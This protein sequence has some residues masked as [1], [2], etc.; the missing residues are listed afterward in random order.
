MDTKRKLQ[1]VAAKQFGGEPE[2]YDVGRRARIPQGECRQG[3]VVRA[4]RDRGHCLGGRYD[5]H[6]LPTDISTLTKQSATALAGLGLMGVAKDNYGLKGYIQSFVAGFTEVEV[7]V[8]TG[9][10]RILDYLAVADVGTVMNPRGLEAQIDGGGNQ[11]IGH[12]RSQ[13]WVYDQQYGVSLAKR[14]YS[15]TSRR[16]SSIFR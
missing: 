7:D 6:E 14:F 3:S 4:G 9:E 12:A 5:G 2:D 8:E 13:K 16:P 11:G 15:T 1:E 10:F